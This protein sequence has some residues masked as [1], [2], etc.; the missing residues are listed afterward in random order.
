[1]DI[2]QYPH[3]QQQL[4]L[5]HVA[6]RGEWCDRG[7]MRRRAGGRQWETREAGPLLIDE[8]EEEE[9]KREGRN[10]VFRL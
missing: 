9:D 3:R 4:P 2:T 5:H 8:E 1:M 10:G 6:Q 7:K